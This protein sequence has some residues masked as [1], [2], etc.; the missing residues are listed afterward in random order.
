MRHL[1]RTWRMASFR[2][3]PA[4]LFLASGGASVTAQPVVASG[5]AVAAFSSSAGGP[6]RDGG[7]R[8]WAR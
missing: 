2:A 7:G 6:A 1:T 5:W 8:I 3:G 4:W